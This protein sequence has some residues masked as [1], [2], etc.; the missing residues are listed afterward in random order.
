MRPAGHFAEATPVPF[1][2]LIIWEENIFTHKKSKS[3]HTW[4]GHAAL[5][6]GEVFDPPV[7]ITNV[8]PNNNYVSWWPDEG[9]SFGPGAVFG[10][11]KTKASPHTTLMEDIEC[12]GYLPD[13][14]IKLHVYNPDMLNYMQAEWNAI[15]MKN[16]ASYHSLRKNCSTIVARVL[17]AGNFGNGGSYMMDG[18]RADKKWSESS[19]WVWSP[20]SFRGSVLQSKGGG[21]D[22]STKAHLMYSWK[23]FCKEIEEKSPGPASPGFRIPHDSKGRP[24][25]QPRDK[26]YSAWGD[27][28]A[29]YG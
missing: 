28:E 17:L 1:S 11:G 7:G 23:Q 12:E 26:A 9:V 29:K 15:R 13:Y 2:Y 21:T 24:I 25:T 20:S 8:A 19:H 3:G 4:P 16:N 22:L 6:I 27:I 18:S 5:N 10:G 14:V